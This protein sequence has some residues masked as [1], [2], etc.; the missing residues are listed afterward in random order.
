MFV[1]SFFSSWKIRNERVF[2]CRFCA[3]NFNNNI[4][5]I[6][7]HFQTKFQN[8]N[9]ADQRFGE[10]I[11]RSLYWKSKVFW[12][13]TLPEQP[14]KLGANIFFKRYSIF[15]LLDLENIKNVSLI[16]LLVRCQKGLYERRLSF[17]WD[18]SGP[19]LPLRKH[20]PYRL[21]KTYHGIGKHTH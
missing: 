7:R 5:L 14:C 12:K 9:T 17:L 19:W 1:L 20:F 10:D 16:R 15:I 8:S 13:T 6:Y 21:N 4:E 3:W 18:I 2:S 11:F